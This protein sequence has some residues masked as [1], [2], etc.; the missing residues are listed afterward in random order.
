MVTA[1][2]RFQIVSAAAQVAPT[3]SGHAH[4]RTCTARVVDDP[5][6]PGKFAGQRF[7]AF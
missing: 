7:K 5:D 4:G 6:C 3:Y 2:H 1:R